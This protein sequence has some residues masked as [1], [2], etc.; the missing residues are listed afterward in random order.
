MP[1]GA[2]LTI[3]T[4]RGIPL[5]DGDLEA[6]EG[7]PGPVAALKDADRRRGR[8]APRHAGVQQLDPGRAQE[9]GR[10]AVPAAGRHRRVF[11]GKPVALMGASPGGFGTVLAQNAWLPVLR[12]LGAE[13]WSGGRLLVS[14]AQAVLGED[15]TL[16]DPKIREQLRTFVQG[17]AAFAR[18]SRRG[19]SA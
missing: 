19:A 16:S 18:S 11:G 14:R 6:A 17:F 4:I 8:P 7:I 13:L 9:R 5:Y 10:L 15:G 3:G 2:E 12:T 1:E